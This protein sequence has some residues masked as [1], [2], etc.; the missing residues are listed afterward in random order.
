MRSLRVLAV[1]SEVYPLIKTGGLADVVGAL[2]I[3]LKAHGIETRTLVPGYPEVIKALPL[4]VELLNVANFFGGPVRLL[5]GSHGGLD[6]MIFDAPHLF[7]RPGNPY[8][9]AD[10]KDWPDNGL[11]FAALC[12]VAAEIGLGAIPSFLPDVVHCH[13]WQAGLVPAYLHHANGHRSASVMTIHNLAYP[14]QFPKEMLELFGLPPESFTIDGVEYY[15]TISFLKAGLR[16]ADR[17]TTVSP[18]YAKEILE[19]PGGMGFAGLLRLRSNVLS[20]ILN[21]IDSDVWNP[22]TDRTIA[23]PFS[24]QD[25][26]TRKVNKSALQHQYGLK[27]DSSRLLLG[28]VSRLTWQKGLDLVLD[29]LTTI[30]DSGMQLVVLGSGDTDLQDRLLEGGKRYPGVVGVK[31]GYDE[32]LA[33]LIQAGADATLVPSRFEPCGLTQLCALR[34]GSVPIVSR[35]GGLA[36]TV[37]DFETVRQDQGMA[38]G[39]TFIPLTGEAFNLALRRVSAMW[40]DQ[41]AWRRLQRAGMSK[42]VS[43]RSRAKQYADLYLA[44]TEQRKPL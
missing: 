22:E 8:V 12:R 37:E 16:F 21:G 11:R 4:A 35:V 10:G 34:Y 25:I 30:V 13:D 42:D 18:T 14:G 15:G 26:E 20:G 29:N 24:A 17:I 31:I 1:A 2:P 7:A 6:L 44:V 23:A 32:A 39:F 40:R 3:E 33:H 43:W 38:T 9:S 28:M 19:E 5:A 27:Q 41:N 36:D